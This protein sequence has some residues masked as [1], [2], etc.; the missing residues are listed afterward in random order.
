MN[1]NCKK[2][3]FWIENIF[4]LDSSVEDL[5]SKMNFLSIL[6]LI[7]CLVMY[8]LKYNNVILLLSL[9]LIIIIIIYYIQKEMIQKKENYAQFID[10]EKM[11]DNK[12]QKKNEL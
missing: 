2:K 12:R 5:A 1:E 9:L 11:Y 4:Y 8:Y 3:L 10:L 7:I 6:A